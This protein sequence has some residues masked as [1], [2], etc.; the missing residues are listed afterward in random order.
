[1]KKL[2]KEQNPVCL[3]DTLDDTVAMA[4]SSTTELLYL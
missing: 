3:L 2:K 1:M 4:T